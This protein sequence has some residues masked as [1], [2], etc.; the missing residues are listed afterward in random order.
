MPLYFF[1]IR[2]DEITEDYEGADLPDDDAAHATGIK[3]ARSLAADAVKSGSF[4]AS[5]HIEVLDSERNSI[6]TIRFD[7]AVELRP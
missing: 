1:N 4:T 7:E 6:T 2:N 3:A 5:H